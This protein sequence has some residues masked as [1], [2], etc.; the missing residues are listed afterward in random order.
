MPIHTS[1]N[2]YRR[3]V[4]NNY[5]GFFFVAQTNNTIPVPM[6]KYL[7][8]RTAYNRNIVNSVSRFSTLPWRG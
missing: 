7:N 1:S 8:Q 4:P 6:S 5:T 3:G 2:T